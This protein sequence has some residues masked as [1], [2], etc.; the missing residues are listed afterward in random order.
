MVAHVA[1]AQHCLRAWQ[2]AV[3]HLHAAGLPAAAPEFV[4]RWLSRQ[5][6]PV[7]WTYPGRWAA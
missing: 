7:D 5:G 3:E 6:I 4:A 1:D 2:S